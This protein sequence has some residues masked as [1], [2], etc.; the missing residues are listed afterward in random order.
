MLIAALDATGESCSVAVA[1][2]REVLAEVSSRRT[3]SQ[4]RNLVPALEAALNQAGVRLAELD[5]LAVT[6]GPGSFTGVRLGVV[7]AAT[8][9]QAAD[10]PVAAV[11]SL[12]ALSR[13]CPGGG[14][15]VAACDARKGE[16]V[17]AAFRPDR[18][19]PNRLLTPGDFHA[20]VRDLSPCWVV[21]NALER[22]PDLPGGAVAIPR[23][24]WWVRASAVARLGQREIR[25][26]RGR[27]WLELRPDY[28]RPAEVQVHPIREG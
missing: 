2:D 16:I 3:R 8:L 23:D 28:V 13:N 19:G 26:G 22:Y 17:A 1:D 5:A 11:D 25:E 7:T 15:V 4:L 12:E 9:A 21:G 10:L 27:T 18:V 6:V 24:A 14:C 20:W